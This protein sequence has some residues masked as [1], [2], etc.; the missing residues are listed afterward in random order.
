MFSRAAKISAALIFAAM[1]LISFANILSRYL[2]H[3]SFAATEEITL[4][5]F[6][7]LTVVGTGL[8]FERGAHLGMD[9]LFKRLSPRCQ[10]LTQRIGL[11]LSLLFVIIVN[12]F[13]MKSIYF[14]LTLFHARSPALGIPIAFYLAVVPVLSVFVLSGIFKA[15][16]AL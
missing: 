6:V 15:I 11:V 9:I 13:V 8:A 4:N 1:A 5:L 10:D 7:A 12:F 3:F 2:F 14:E 16:K